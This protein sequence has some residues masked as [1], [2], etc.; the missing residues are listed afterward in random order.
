MSA[1]VRLCIAGGGTGGHVMPALALAE[2]VR[3]RWPAVDVSFVGAERGLEA[4]L[5]P[6]RGE[7][8]LLLPMHAFQGQ[9]WWSRIKV[10]AWEL[11]RAVLR[12]RRAW[13]G[14]RP[15]LVVGVGGY[16]SVAGVLAAAVSRVPVVLYEQNAMPGMVNRWLAS[17]A[18]VVMLGFAEAAG[19]LP[20]AKCRHTGNIVAEAMHKVS[21]QRHERPCLL[22][23]G[24]SQGAAFL[25]D[26]LPEACRL[27]AEQGVG[28][29]VRHIAGERGDAVDELN[30]RYQDAG[31][32]A[33]VADFC[34]D[35]PGFYATGDVLIARSGAMT[36]SEVAVVGM[37]AVF[38]P[39]PWAADDHQ[40][41]NADVLAMHGA[42]VILDQ[43]D[44]TACR[45]AELLAALLADTE[46]LTAMSTRA[47]QA[48]PRDA[49]ERQL[50]VLAPWL[51]GA[52]AVG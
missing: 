41:R 31:V 34:H 48:M 27:L 3:R 37:P 5:L 52:G 40:H 13:R 35:M 23:F 14:R 24:G 39:F 46:R 43:N 20:Q 7:R 49:R 28:L 18:R 26:I 11:P 1:A 50:D 12:L 51:A 2:A 17:L 29:R 6:E 47:R 44:A 42:A 45:L 9:G 10:L 36:V 38:L 33:E 8:V 25:N 16:A 30:R 4:R 21:W 19:R 32:D 15:Q 22:V